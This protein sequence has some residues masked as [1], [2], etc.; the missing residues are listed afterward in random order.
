MYKIST[1]Y[2]L[3]EKSG[4]MKSSFVKC[5]QRILLNTFNTLKEEKIKN[6]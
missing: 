6:N 5:C 4:K 2:R 1:I 3:Y